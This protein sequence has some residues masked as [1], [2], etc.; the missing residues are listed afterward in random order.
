[1][2][3]S[4]DLIRKYTRK[5]NL[6]FYETLTVENFLMIEREYS[7]YPHLWDIFDFHLKLRETLNN[8]TH[9]GNY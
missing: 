4:L 9:E 8:I 1:M 3:I 2:S 7:F 6:N 5:E